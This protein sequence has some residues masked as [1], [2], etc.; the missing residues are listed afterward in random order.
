MAVSRYKAVSR[1]MAVFRYMAAK[2]SSDDLVRWHVLEH[3]R[4]DRAWPWGACSPF[5]L[6]E[7]ILHQY[8]SRV[9]PLRPY[10]DIWRYPDIRRCPGMAV[11]RY[12][13]WRCP[14]IRRYPDIWRY[15]DIWRPKPVVKTL[16]GGMSSSIRARIV[17]GLGVPAAHFF[18]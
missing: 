8:Y 18:Y 17:L 2:T 6:L 12:T 1:Y 14:D 3:S 10:P 15:S 16:Y 9:P 11:S 4:K 7:S 5:F 13:V